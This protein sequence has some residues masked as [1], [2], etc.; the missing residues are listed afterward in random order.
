MYDRS[1]H[2]IRLKASATEALAQQFR[3][4][5]EVRRVNHRR[6]ECLFT[7][8]KRLIAASAPVMMTRFPVNSIHGS[9]SADGA[10]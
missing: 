3:H 5:A 1:R 9:C 10:G 2:G 6:N 4:D 7:S 8:H